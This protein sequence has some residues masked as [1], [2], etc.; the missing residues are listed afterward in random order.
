MKFSRNKFNVAAP[1]ARSYK[2]R[3]YDSKAEMLYAQRLDLLVKIGEV[4]DY[5][6]QPKV[7]IAGE[8]WYRPDFLV[9]EQNDA[10]YV[11]VKGMSTS[12]FKK[13]T[14]AWPSRIGLRLK[15]IKRVGDTFRETETIDGDNG[16]VCKQHPKER[17]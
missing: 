4:V 2:G 12:A 5:C 15:V 11:D 17:V 1:V 10:Y 9:I 6:E 13:I 3:V 16:N 7:H 14:D 8:L